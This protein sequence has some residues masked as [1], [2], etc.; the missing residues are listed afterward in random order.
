MS[1]ISHIY[2]LGTAFDS[3][4]KI[5]KGILKRSVIEGEKF[6]FSKEYKKQ[7][8]KLGHNER[9]L[10]YSWVDGSDFNRPETVGFINPENGQIDQINYVKQKIKIEVAK[11]SRSDKY[12]AFHNI[13][14]RDERVNVLE[15][16]TLFFQ[17]N[18]SF[19]VI[20]FTGIP[21]MLRRVEKLVKRSLSIDDNYA[22][23]ADAMEFVWLFYASDENNGQLSKYLNLLDI[24]GFSGKL[25]STA[26][27]NISSGALSM[28]KYFILKAFI[29][30]QYTFTGVKLEL[31][32]VN[33]QGKS[34]GI[35]GF[36][37][38]NNNSVKVEERATVVSLFSSEDNKVLM[39]L[40]VYSFILPQLIKIYSAKHSLPDFD[41]NILEYH[42]KL[43]MDVIK[44][45][46][47]KNPQLKL[48]GADMLKG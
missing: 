28:S 41:Q 15:I 38:D 32:L 36:S 30:L 14:P 31:Q 40:F 16:D 25:E 34:G 26:K 2:K 9:V 23:D 13:R 44:M 7:A 1:T 18:N 27:T 33:L 46:I 48:L 8:E 43:G 24:E 20:V 39:T 10:F 22:I 11:K 21:K 6:S 42:N 35:L 12:D 19:F 45:I 3:F 4:S 29:A 17:T 47:E 5:E 37:F